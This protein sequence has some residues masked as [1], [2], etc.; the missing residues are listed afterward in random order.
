MYYII[1]VK[2]GYKNPIEICKMVFRN[3]DLRIGRIKESF[4]CFATIIYSI[5]TSEIGLFG[6]RNY[7]AN[8]HARM[9]NYHVLLGNMLP[10]F[11][12]TATRQRP[13]SLHADVEYEGLR[14]LAGQRRKGKELTVQ[15]N[16]LLSRDICPRECQCSSNSIRKEFR[17]TW[18]VS[19]SFSS[20]FRLCI[21]KKDTNSRSRRIQFRGSLTRVCDCCVLFP[22][23]VNFHSVHFFPSL[24]K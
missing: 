11:I 13:R 15:K 9:R 22:W 20:R 5:Q 17:G 4:R 8:L 23:S 24:S 10:K 21:S 3:L 16:V 14:T 6:F 12:S 7:C 2:S 19:R 18:I 1:D